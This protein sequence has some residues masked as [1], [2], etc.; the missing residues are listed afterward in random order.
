MNLGTNRRALFLVAL[1]ALWLAVT[2]L[3][4]ASR[5]NPEGFLLNTLGRYS[6]GDAFKHLNVDLP[7][8]WFMHS[9]LV[10]T[11]LAAARS[12]RTDVLIVLLIGP[13]FALAVNLLGQDWSDPNW[14]VIVGVCVIGWLASTVVG[15]VYWCQRPTAS[16]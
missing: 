4:V 1:V 16:R 13:N 11:A 3:L 9:A 15:I 10:S 12:R 5:G 14:S 7:R 8:F 2:G 6:R